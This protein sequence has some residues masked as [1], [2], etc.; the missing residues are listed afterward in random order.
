MH[1]TQ[2]DPVKA[3]VAAHWNRRAAHF[4]ADFGH[5]IATA[6][7]RAAWDRILDLITAGRPGL[8]ALDAGCGTG[9]LSFE[10]AARGHRVTG[11]DFAPAMLEAAR[12]KAQE[13]GAAVRFE[14]GDAEN[15]RF[16][17]GSFDLAVSRHVLWTLPHPEAAIAEWIRV[18]R[19]GG[20]LAVIDSQFDASV[21]T[22]PRENARASTEYAGIGDKL[23]FLGG[24]PLAEIEA[25][26]AA[27]GLVEIGS[28]P[29]AD[30]VTAHYER[31]QA[32]GLPPQRRRRY[33][34]WGR[35][36]G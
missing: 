7:E 3:A 36:P 4:D 22:N 27:K 5:S 33:V 10:L 6:A 21:L 26:L 24:R 32:E 9:F 29:V 31:M 23:P 17:A 25:L 19:P 8:D 2:P 13:N 34:A 30:L 16:A 35:V 28:D 1:S 20:R 14:Q 18:L 12:A 15:L 11:I